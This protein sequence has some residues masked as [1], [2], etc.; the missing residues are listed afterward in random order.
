[1]CM[2]RFVS[3]MLAGNMRMTRTIVV[4]EMMA[5]TRSSLHPYGYVTVE[6]PGR[7]SRQL[8][9]LLGDLA[10]MRCKQTACTNQYSS[11]RIRVSWWSNLLSPDSLPLR[12]MQSLTVSSTCFINQL[13]FDVGTVSDAWAEQC[14]ST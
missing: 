13:C 6:P 4:I 3:Y 14:V 5:L 8:P 10:S 11:Q 1:M 7:S 2:K 12:A 9:M